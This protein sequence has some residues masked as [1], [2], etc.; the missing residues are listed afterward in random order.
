MMRTTTF[1]SFIVFLS[2]QH[3]A[4]G[5][6]PEASKKSSAWQR[7]V[8]YQ[9][10]PRSFADSN[11]DGV[12]D[13]RGITQHVDY[14]H[15]LGV[16]MVWLNPIY[17]ST[18]FDGGYDVSDYTAIDPAYGTLDDWYALRDAL[19]A[20]GMRIMMDMVLN[21]SSDGHPWFIQEKRLKTLQ[22]GLAT[23]IM[24][25]TPNDG[26][27]IINVIADPSDVLDGASDA[28]RQ[29]ARLV[30]TYASED[31]HEATR[32]GYPNRVVQM[33]SLAEALEPCVGDHHR[34]LDVARPFEDFYIWR[35]TPNN[36]TS[37]FSGSAWHAVPGTGGYYLAI[38]TE[39]QI[40][41]NWRNPTLRHAVENIIGM[42]EKRGVDGFR[43]DSAETLSK[44][45]TFPDGTNTPD[46]T[47]RGKALFSNLP[48]VHHYLHELAH[49][50]KPTIRTIG[51][52]AFVGRDA[53][54]YYAGLE[55]GE[56]NEVFLF[57]QMAI[58][59]NGTKWRRKPF[60]LVDFKQ[61]IATQQS[62]IHGRAWL[63]NFLENH[64]NLRIVSRYGDAQHYRVASAKAFASLL[65]TIEGTPYIYQGQ[66]LGMTDLPEGTF[67]KIE[68]VDDVEGR[69]YYTNHVKLGESPAEVFHQVASRNRDHVRSAMQWDATTFAGFSTRTPKVRLNDNHDTI[70]VQASQKDPESVMHY[71]ARMIHGRHSHDS[72]VHGAY[73]DLLPNDPAIFAYTKTTA[74]EKSIVLLNMSSSEQD[75]NLPASALPAHVSESID[76]YP[77]E[78]GPLAAHVHLRPWESRIVIGVP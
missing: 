56:L 20:R 69:N 76:S 24:Q 5:A 54:V 44:N 19:H 61:V 12:G 38:F 37:L 33:A 14:L 7:D 16:N 45:P 72:W 26:E 32:L 21:H 11:G 18:H 13:L 29:A 34:C 68:D 55:R 15:A 77:E 65:M 52:A 6:A 4:L 78:V 47:G 42:W 74:E 40:D 8:V 23:L 58:D 64:D 25:A 67:K 36:W 22:H 51:E 63:G 48:E 71:Y 41:L 27:A 1:A 31:D 43:L 28:V 62:V 75:V 50:I 53:P 60:K 57:G 17:Q 73:L 30:N 70:N 39:H 49:T 46:G 10:Y 59:C 35:E 9:V 2:F 66:E 3:A